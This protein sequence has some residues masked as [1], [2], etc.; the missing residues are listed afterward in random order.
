M[1]VVCCVLCV[2]CVTSCAPGEPLW[3]LVAV[4]VWEGQAGRALLGG[5]QQIGGVFVVVAE[6]QGVVVCAGQAVWVGLQAGPLVV[7]EGHGEQGLRVAHK[8]VHVP[9]AGHLKGGMSKS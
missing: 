4:A 6:R 2:L 3:C 1:C 5:V 8:L 7:G 9:L